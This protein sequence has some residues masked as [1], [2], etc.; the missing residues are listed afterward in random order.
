MTK[1]KGRRSLR[2]G[3]STRSS[4]RR[5]ARGES[6]A[7][8]ILA[9]IYIVVI[10]L[11]V[12]ALSGLA[13]NDLNNTPKFAAATELDSAATNMTE[14]AI[15]YV[16]YNPQITSSTASG[17]ASPLVSCWGGTSLSQLP[18]FNTYQIAVWCSTNWNPLSAQTR[19][20][21][22]YACQSSLLAA[23]CASSPLLQ[24]VVIFDDYPAP[25][26]VSAPNQTICTVLCGQGMT[27]TS[28]IFGG[29]T[30]GS[31]SGIATALSFTNEP[32]DVSVGSKTSAAVTVLDANGNPVAGD[33]VTIIVQSGPG[34]LDPTS[35]L[36]TITNTSGVASFSNLV[37]DLSGS[38]I[39][40]A[41]DGSVTKT[42]TNFVVSKIS[43][44]ISGVS[45]APSRGT[46]GG[47]K[48][49][50]SATAASGDIVAITLDASSTGC[51][52]SGGVVSFTAAGTCV[53]DFNDLGNST[54]GAAPQIQQS[55]PVTSSVSGS[56]TGGSRGNLPNGGAYYF[57][58]QMNSPGSTNNH[59]AY[60]VTPGVA[61]TLKSLTF[62]TNSPSP[63]DQSA[64][65][66]LITSNTW[67]ATGLTCTVPGGSGQTICTITLN[68]S[69]PAGSSINVYGSG[70]NY[71][72]GTWTVT[73]TQP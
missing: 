49:T 20:V 14:V 9:L 62:K 67:L 6:G 48:Y 23:Q 35:T 1:I 22:F 15:Q 50:P 59:L 26:R 44:S 32:S 36:S 58:N 51:T 27:L 46:V 54:Y 57:I 43:N 24:T 39:L 61:T 65:V 31:V 72:S 13:I 71:H 11:V 5:N 56:Y 63:S 52:I 40:L 73:Y 55:I 3:P 19:Q 64:T 68:V 41:A 69:I 7:V 10:S 8:L 2:L 45:T 4:S 16:R 29:T 28:W 47:A 34:Q 53:V 60:T 66:G 70:N 12:A 33:T 42:S 37:P 30:S 21:T 17:V 18:T 38:Y 25:P